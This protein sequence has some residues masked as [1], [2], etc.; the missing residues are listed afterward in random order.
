MVGADVTMLCSTLLRNGVDHIRF[1]AR[2]LLHWMQ[3]HEYESVQQMKGSMSQIYC[4]NPSAF[5]RAQYTRAV[6]TA[7]YVALSS[8]AAW[9][10]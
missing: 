9:K 7:Q 4:A 2:G 1:I 5:E 6:R 3:E 10:I 8:R